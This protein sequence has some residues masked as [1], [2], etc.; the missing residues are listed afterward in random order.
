MKKNPPINWEDLI[1]IGMNSETTIVLEN[2][3][4]ILDPKP[5]KIINQLIIQTS[6]NPPPENNRFEYLRHIRDILISL[7][8]WTQFSDSPLSESKKAQWVNYRQA[9]RDLPSTY[10]GDGPIN[11]PLLPKG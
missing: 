8:D 5:S 7:T 6:N 9:L 1:A 11:W 10:V 3:N 2:D 4:F